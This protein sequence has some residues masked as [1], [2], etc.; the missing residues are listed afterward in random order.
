MLRLSELRWACESQ[1]ANTNCSSQLCS[2]IESALSG[3]YLN[4]EFKYLVLT[5]VVFE[6]HLVYS[7]KHCCAVDSVLMFMF[8]LMSILGLHSCVEDVLFSHCHFRDE[9]YSR[10]QEMELSWRSLRPH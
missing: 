9:R 10:G 7:H 3:K 2:Q 8:L 5:P 4:L 6:Q 1:D